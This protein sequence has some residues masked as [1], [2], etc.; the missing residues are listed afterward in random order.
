MGM[1]FAYNEASFFMI[2]LLQT[3]DTITHDKEAQP[4]WSQPPSDWREG[5]NKTKRKAKEE[6]W[7][8]T[9]LVTSIKVSLSL[10]ILERKLTGCAGRLL[11]ENEG[12]PK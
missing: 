12:G 6:I 1:D 11:G 8:E 10:R 4:L 9:S 3:F 2:R 7:P 5:V